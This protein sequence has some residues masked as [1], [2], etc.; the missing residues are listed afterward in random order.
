MEMLIN[1]QQLNIRNTRWLKILIHLSKLKLQVLVGAMF[2][3]SG[4]RMEDMGEAKNLYGSV[5]AVELKNVV[6]GREIVK[7]R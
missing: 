3:L 7:E 1:L 2:H 4:L 6:D 5:S